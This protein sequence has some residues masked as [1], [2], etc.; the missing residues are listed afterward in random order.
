MSPLKQEPQTAGCVGW[1]TSMSLAA[2]GLS[3]RPR[4]R[5]PISLETPCHAALGKCR[6]SLN[7]SFLLCEVGQDHSPP[8]V[9]G[10][11]EELYV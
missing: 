5:A 7:L 1:V 6:P 2:R 11:R 9:A 10:L 4:P 8:R 3:G